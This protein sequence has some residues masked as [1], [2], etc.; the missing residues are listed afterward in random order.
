MNNLHKS[1]AMVYGVTY[2]C[3][4][5]FNTTL[6]LNNGVTFAEVGLN[7]INNVGYMYTDVFNA[8]TNTP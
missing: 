4:Q 3:Y 5:A 6:G 2:N 7:V 1:I 8:L